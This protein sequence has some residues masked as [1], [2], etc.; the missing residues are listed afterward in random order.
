MRFKTLY[1]NGKIIDD[2]AD[3]NTLLHHCAL[4]TF[5]DGTVVESDILGLRRT[6]QIV[7]VSANIKGYQVEIVFHYCQFNMYLNI[8][9]LG[10]NNQD[11]I[12]LFSNQTKS[13]R[14]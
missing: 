1:L 10:F 3:R 5:S 4:F 6:D 9:I 8:D 2:I 13:A 12:G 7:R 11:I 14:K